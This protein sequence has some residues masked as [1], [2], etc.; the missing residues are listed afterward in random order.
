MADLHGS[1][2]YEKVVFRHIHYL[3][4]W[5]LAGLIPNVEWT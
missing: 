1:E 2:S 3:Y 4:V 5:T